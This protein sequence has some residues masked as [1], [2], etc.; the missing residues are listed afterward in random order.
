MAISC[1]IIKEILPPFGFVFKLECWKCGWSY[2]LY[3]EMD[4]VNH[5]TEKINCEV[6]GFQKEEEEEEEVEAAQLKQNQGPSIGLIQSPQ[7]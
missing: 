5:K 2:V 3:S 7:P 4:S 1:D 6:Q